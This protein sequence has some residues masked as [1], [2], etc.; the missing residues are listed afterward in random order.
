MPAELA[1]IATPTRYVVCCVPETVRGWHHWSLVVEYRG[2]DRWVVLDRG[3]ALASDG[4]WDVEP[5]PSS[6]SDWWIEAH[7]FDLETALQMAR[8]KAPHMNVNGL[9]PA[10]VLARHATRAASV[11]PDTTQETQP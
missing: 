1:A 4:T 8:H 10:D 3:E 9:T 6:R 2:H 7:Y 5:S 11:A